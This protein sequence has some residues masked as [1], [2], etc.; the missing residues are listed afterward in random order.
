MAA[1]VC[2]PLVRALRQSRRILLRLR[3]RRQL[4]VLPCRLLLWCRPPKVRSSM[5]DLLHTYSVVWRQLG[6]CMCDVG[7]SD[8]NYLPAV[9]QR[10]CDFSV[11][12]DFFRAMRWWFFGTCSSKFHAGADDQRDSC[13]VS[14]TLMASILQSKIHFELC[15][16]PP[17]LQQTICHSLR[18]TRCTLAVLI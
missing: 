18:C 2:F 9:S 11:W 3:A 5:P 6:G 10:V 8:Q 4:P 12:F 13:D 15:S 17:K 14:A 1:A 7:E 16:S